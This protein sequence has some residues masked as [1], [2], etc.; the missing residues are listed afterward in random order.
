M[1]ALTFRTV[2]VIE[3]PDIDEWL[4]RQ[5]ALGREAHDQDLV[6]WWT[7]YRLLGGAKTLQDVTGQRTRPAAVAVRAASR[8]I[9]LEELA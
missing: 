7:A 8:A 1:S 5:E 3:G 9:P 4:D 6:R 2:T